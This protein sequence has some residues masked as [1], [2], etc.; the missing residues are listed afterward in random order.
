MA[1][2]QYRHYDPV[3]G[4]W[5]SRD[6][7]EEEGGI[8][9]YG[10]VENTLVS[11]VDYLGFQAIPENTH[12]I[13][14]G[15]YSSFSLPGSETYILYVVMNHPLQRKLFRHYIGESGADLPISTEEYLATRP[16][17]LSITQA[18]SYFS[19]PQPGE[20]DVKN[21]KITLGSDLP[22]AL[23]DH[24][25]IF[26]GKLCID[27]NGYEFSGTVELDETYDFDHRNGA[28][29]VRNIKAWL[30]R[31]AIVGVRYTVVY[32]PSSF[33]EKNFKSKLEGQPIN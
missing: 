13:S 19:D 2:Y 1:D 33:E 28:S 3:T 17:H 4:R 15:P 26:N 8:N 14:S 9:L 16:R 7:I 20:Y 24:N 30:V 5:P 21:E 10:F 11:R 22:M 31:S 29:R 18:K 25:M 6:P 12:N 32:G 27:D 23:N